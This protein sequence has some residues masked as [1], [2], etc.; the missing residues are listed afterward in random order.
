[1]TLHCSLTSPETLLRPDLLTLIMKCYLTRWSRKSRQPSK[2][3]AGHS[4]LSH[5]SSQCSTPF[6]SH[7]CSPV[8]GLSPFVGVTKSMTSSLLLGEQKGDT[9]SPP[10]THCYGGHRN[11]SKLTHSFHGG[12]IIMLSTIFLNPEISVL[13][14]SPVQEL[15]VVKV[16]LDTCVPGVKHLWL[17]V[18][19]QLCHCSSKKIDQGDL[20]EILMGLWF[21]E[22]D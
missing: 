2:S 18:F 15:N 21:L 12:Q 14:S 6:G 7:G 20:L 1:M 11:N 13:S 4:P 16:D 8:V 3:I 17:H 19:I 10:P 22:D 5:S 9:C